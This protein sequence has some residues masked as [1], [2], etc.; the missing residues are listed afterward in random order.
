MDTSTATIKQNQI[1]YNEMALRNIFGWIPTYFRA[2]YLECDS[3][4]QALLGTYGYHVIDI[5]LDT[6]DYMYDD[7][8]LIQTSKDRFS[9][10]V[11]KDATTHSYI[12]LSHDIHEQTVTN[13]T[14]YMINTLRA[15]GYRPV[16]VGECLGDPPANW[17]RDASGISGGASSSV[18]VAPTS[19]IVAVPPTSSPTVVP[20][21]SPT[22]SI[23]GPSDSSG[24]IKVPLTVS[25]DQTCG[26]TKKYTCQGSA[27][28]NCCSFY[29]FWYVSLH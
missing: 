29:G 28:G 9:S 11:S 1:I 22:T 16:T 10:G 3:T 15:R 19:S 13:L 26:G 4:C 24:P 2:P 27:F 7:P 18:V 21:V 20:P 17:Y 14:A 25:P 12:E 6:K 8:T 23:V 5:N